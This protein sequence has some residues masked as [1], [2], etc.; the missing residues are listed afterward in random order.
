MTAP[1]DT[2]PAADTA[3][4]RSTT[5]ALQRLA[6]SIVRDPGLSEDVVQSAYVTALEQGRGRDR[7]GWLRRVVRNRAIDARRRQRLEPPAGDALEPRS[8]AASADEVA[9]RIETQRAVLD[10]VE[11][12]DQPYRDTV[13]LRYF[14][15]LRV[16]E[17]A[18][19]MGVPPKTVETR[20][21]RALAA[22]RARLGPRYRD[23]SSG[24]WTP[25]LAAFA[26]PRSLLPPA[27]TLASV[28]APLLL[29]AMKKIAVT[30]AAVAALVAVG[31]FALDPMRER[32][33]ARATSSVAAMED[34]DRRPDD[35]LVPVAV[36]RSPERVELED[37]T[38]PAVAASDEAVTAAPTHGALRVTVRWKDGDPAEGVGVVVV[39]P[40]DWG[41]RRRVR[42]VTG[43]GGVAFFTGLAPGS[44]T[45][46]T[47]RGTYDDDVDAEVVAGET[48][49]CS[50]ELPDGIDV[51]GRVVDADG[52]PV[53]GASVM[54][55][56]QTG[57]WTQWPSVTEADAAGRFRLR[58]VQAGASIGAEAPGYER[59]LLVDLDAVDKEVQPVRFDLVLHRG[60]GA[61]EGLVTDQEGAPVEGAIVALGRFS[62][63]MNM[64]FDGS[65]EERW[66]GHTARTDAE[67]R[68][69]FD[70][71]KAAKHAMRVRRRGMPQWS[72]EVEVESGQVGR[73]DVELQACATLTGI[74]RDEEGQPVPSARVHAFDTPLDETF[75]QSGQIDY[76][77][78]FAHEAA[79]TGEDGRYTLDTLPPMAMYVYAQA[80]RKDRNDWNE[81]IQFTR[82]TIELEAGATKKWDPILS[83]GRS[84]HGTVRYRDGS[85]IENIFINLT[86]ADGT[87]REHRADHIAGG[88]FR[89]IQLQ[90]ERYDIRAQIWDLPE[91][92]EEPRAIGVVPGGDPVELV[93]DF[94]APVEYEDTKITVR[95]SD[96]GDRAGSD[97]VSM[98]LENMEK[99]SWSIG[100]QEGDAWVFTL[101]TPGRYRAIALAD[102]RLLASGEPFDFVPGEPLDLGTLRSVPGGTVV[103]RLIG[104]DEHPPEGASM[105][106][107]HDAYRHGQRV[108]LDSTLEARLEGIEPG[109]GELHIWGKNFSTVRPAYEVRAGEETLVEVELVPAHRIR[110][111]ID[112]PSL[113]TSTQFTVRFIDVADG[114]E[115]S[116][117]ERK[118][119]G[120]YGNPLEWTALLP[121]G[122]YR[123]DAT[124]GD[125]RSAS[126]SLTVP[127]LG[128]EELPEPAVDLR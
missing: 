124:L 65:N 42:V 94:D 104:S 112:L 41:I 116:K 13:Y 8:N 51:E 32:D 1:R 56:A 35:D 85:P 22:L 55:T 15:G 90:G 80:P 50:V 113:E 59:S 81:V 57:G 61:L 9:E 62:G 79:L 6:Q 83:D 82:A 3:G 91:G 45:V 97:P 12:L 96:D 39:T 47:D 102:E 98:S 109:E 38:E 123:L 17:V 87:E 74:V 49:A 121:P 69:R 76:K 68:Y 107:R 100:Q 103:V 77:G 128:T 71:V 29:L 2:D 115:A 114:S 24:R 93:A 75:L 88:E 43:A 101:D 63:H 117:I 58:D 78:A 30:S 110:Y 84:I 111:R 48:V 36:E 31:W 120:A 40:W 19:R 95:F 126:T 67:G 37:T 28:S 5:R 53:A 105:S 60:G 99:Y 92:A 7:V 127:P 21:T 64:R 18:A 44:F 125:G 122:Q 73:R 34:R 108:D 118:D 54:M 11:R 20:L 27:A 119:I 46:L 72:G 10:A 66:G 70:S 26:D 52:S 33:D 16:R 106:L 25:A 4:W 86:R 14:E 89:F 23:P